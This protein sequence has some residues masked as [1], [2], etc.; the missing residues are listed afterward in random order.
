MLTPALGIQ[1]SPRMQMVFIRT[2]I[3]MRIVHIIIANHPPDGRHHP[4]GPGSPRATPPRG[5]GISTSRGFGGLS[6]AADH[7]FLHYLLCLAERQA[8]TL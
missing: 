1:S 7:F 6:N 3:I 8:P 5:A 2:W 4:A